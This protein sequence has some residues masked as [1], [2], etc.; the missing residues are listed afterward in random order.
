MAS[1][2]DRDLVVRPILAEERKRFDETLEAN[3]WL[4]ARLVGETMRY[5]ALVNGEWAALIGFGSAALCVRSREE[6]LCWSDS[7]RHR[8]LR[9]ITNNQRTLW[10]PWPQGR[11]IP[12]LS[13]RLSWLS[14]AASIPVV[15]P[16][17]DCGI[18]PLGGTLALR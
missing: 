15:E 16:H 12:H 4:G 18:T 3:H 10:R 5:V 9:F 11:R 1:I 14:R 17:A 2:A 13:W 7:Q 6:L 8:R